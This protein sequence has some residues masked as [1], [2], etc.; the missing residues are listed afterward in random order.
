MKILEGLYN[1]F[2][3]TIFST[4][5]KIERGNFLDRILI[6]DISDRQI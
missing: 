6:E 4:F 5:L 3:D 2:S 1:E